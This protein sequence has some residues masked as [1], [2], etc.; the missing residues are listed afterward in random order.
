MSGQ[1]TTGKLVLTNTTSNQD[2]FD[3]LRVSQ[4]NT[5]IELNH[6]IGK[7]P[8]MIDESITGAGSTSVNITSESYIK[9][10]VNTG[11]TGHVIRQSYEYFPYQPGKSKLMLFSGVL[12]AIEGGVTGVV[13]RVGSY[14]SSI[15]KTFAGAS[16]TGN[17][18]FFELGG[19]N[20]KVLYAV[21]RL[22]DNDTAKV[23]MSS[24]NHDT[25]DGNGP[26]GLI[27]TDFSTAKIFTIDQEWLGVGTVRFGFFINGTFHLGHVFNH[28][29]IGLPSSTAITAPYTK[30]AKLPIRCEILS[31]ITPGITHNA[32]MRMIC[33]T[34]LSEGGFEPAGLN[35]SIGRD[36]AATVGEDLKPIISLKLRETEPYNRK[37]LVLKG[38]SLLNT[39]IRGMQWDLYLL[40]N[41]SGLTAK[42]FVNVDATNSCAMY[43]VSSSGITTTAF[44]VLVD[45]GYADLAGTVNFNYDS[46]LSSPTV[47]S[48]ISGQSRVLALCGKRLGNQNVTNRASLSWI[49]IM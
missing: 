2:A 26:S 35:F 16:G 23:A 33:S 39:T 31:S 45:S 40:H 8:F 13:S 32:E 44:D 19:T 5:L 34:V 36:T 48:S 49:E 27:I 29:G 37:T 28:S 1:L 10:G 22:N 14:D 17:G 11:A 25:F 18:L 9:M 6:T 3:R 47:N 12:G 30:T 21:V 15:N 41:D 43:D 42:N 20:G 46:Y 4:P 24:W 7:M 38:L